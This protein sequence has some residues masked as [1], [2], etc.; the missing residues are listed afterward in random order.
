MKHDPPDVQNTEWV[1]TPI[2]AFMLAGL[3]AKGLKPAPPA[4][5]RILLRRVTL[6]LTGLPPTPAEYKAF[7]RT[8]RLTPSPRL[9]TGCSLPNAMASGGAGIGWMSR[10]MLTPDGLSLAPDPFPNAWRYRDWVIA[11][12]NNDMPYDQ[13]LKAQIAGDLFDKPGERKTDSR[14]RVPCSGPLVF[15]DRGAAEGPCR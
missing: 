1:R 3:D 4:D 14:S 12:F 10:D 6:D 5:R 8:G 13:F 7:V 15:P 2:D 11:A 9:W